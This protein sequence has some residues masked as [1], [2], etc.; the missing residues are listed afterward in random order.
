[1]KTQ[2]ALGYTT[3][4]PEDGTSVQL[5][6]KVVQSKTKAYWLTQGLRIQSRLQ[7]RH[8]SDLPWVYHATNSAWPL[9]RHRV[10]GPGIPLLPG[11]LQL[12]PREW[13]GR[14]W[15]G[16]PGSEHCRFQSYS[17]P[18]SRHIPFQQMQLIAI[19]NKQHNQN[20]L[21]LVVKYPQVM[22]DVFQWIQKQQLE[23]VVLR[24]CLTQQLG[25]EH[26]LPHV[27]LT[28]TI[29]THSERSVCGLVYHRTGSP[30]QVRWT[31]HQNT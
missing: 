1:M 20:T 14:K 2:E 18:L 16:T 21:H 25:K 9:W 7:V 11:W 6:T 22:H 27:S 4:L 5:G 19:S 23:V 12:I 24:Q 31:V 8:G 3:Q 29:K 15:R 17:Q 10:C 13:Q 26:A 28:N 30:L